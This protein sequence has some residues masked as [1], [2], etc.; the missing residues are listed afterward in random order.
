M[1]GIGLVWIAGC[2]V[3]SVKGTSTMSDRLRKGRGVLQA[4]QA[5][6]CQG[7][8]VPA[9]GIELLPESRLPSPPAAAD[10]DQSTAAQPSCSSSRRAMMNCKVHGLRQAK[11]TFAYH[12]S[13]LCSGDKPQQS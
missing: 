12:V 7:N 6:H 3:V 9:A 11:T 4:C 1:V 13:S 5:W 10:G 8:V 2:I